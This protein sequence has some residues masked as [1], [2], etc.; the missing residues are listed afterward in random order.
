MS[1]HAL[2]RRIKGIGQGIPRHETTI[3]Q[4]V[5][6]S[7]A[8]GI[9]PIRDEDEDIDI[10]APLGFKPSGVA[11]IEAISTQITTPIRV[12]MLLSIFLMSFTY[13]LDGSV[14]GSY[15][16]YA[17]SEMGGHALLATVN[18]VRSVIACIAQVGFMFKGHM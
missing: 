8:K 18:V 7:E 16:A 14:R 9:L 2:F 1:L 6:A 11:R 10:A 4:D 15:Q 3:R 12:I 13:G 5:S 17:T